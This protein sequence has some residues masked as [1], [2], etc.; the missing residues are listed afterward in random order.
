ME[1]CDDCP[2]GRIHICSAY[3]PAARSAGKFGKI[4]G[5]IRD[6]HLFSSC[7]HH[8]GRSSV[9][10][11]GFVVCETSL[12]NPPLLVR[13]S[14]AK[15]LHVL[16]PDATF[17]WFNN[18]RETGSPQRNGPQEQGPT[19]LRC[20]NALRRAEGVRP[21]LSRK[22][23]DVAKKCRVL[24][25]QL[26]AGVPQRSLSDVLFAVAGIAENMHEEY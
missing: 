5:K 3:G 25:S 24:N 17:V 18:A 4:R 23:S 6:S 1:N 2:G 13:E 15:H 11:N 16:C 14:F 8:L 22:V 20:H 9:K 12:L 10:G 7:Y 19:R 21:T 26:R